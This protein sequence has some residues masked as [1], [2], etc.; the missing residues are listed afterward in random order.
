MDQGPSE[1][2]FRTAPFAAHAA[3][4]LIRDQRTRRVTMGAL[5]AAAVLMIVVGSTFL[6]HWLA[7]RGHLLWFVL[8]WGACG[9]LTVT[10]LLLAA[11]DLLMLRVQARAA[12]KAF[13]DNLE[14]D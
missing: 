5:L 1:K 8:F 10:A 13:R 14:R 11:F 7:E 12:R 3:R 2:R 6:E 9:W 4:G